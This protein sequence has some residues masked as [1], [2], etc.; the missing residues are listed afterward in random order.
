MR[1]LWEQPWY[2][3]SSLHAKPYAHISCTAI[4]FCCEHWTMCTQRLI[5]Q[6]YANCALLVNKICDMWTLDAYFKSIMMCTWTFHFF[7]SF[8]NLNAM[9]CGAARKPLMILL[10]TFGDALVEFLVWLGPASAL[11]KTVRLWIKEAM[12]SASQVWESSSCLVFACKSIE[13]PSRHHLVSKHP[14]QCQV[15]LQARQVCSYSEV[16]LWRGRNL[17]RW[18]FVRRN[19]AV[20]RVLYIWDPG[21]LKYLPL[22]ILVSLMMM[23]QRVMRKAEHH[24]M[25]R[26][27]P[28]CFM[29]NW[30]PNRLWPRYISYL[31]NCVKKF[32]ETTTL[33]KRLS[34]GIKVCQLFESGV[35]SSIVAARVLSE[36]DS[37]KKNHR[38]SCQTQR[39][40]SYNYFKSFIYF[41]LFQT[42]ECSPRTSNT[43][44]GH[45]SCPALQLGLSSFKLILRMMV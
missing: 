8:D 35:S 15:T 17:C 12:P 19:S 37:P 18:G 33:F 29:H 42:L 39:S 45:F 40:W 1:I 14:S 11:S 43:A 6:C 24:P 9:H 5:A 3:K 34:L 2:Q 13:G 7:V 21:G 30:G 22:S 36:S 32:L 10:K 25:L 38:A 44:S 27:Q 26:S 23:C 28:S 41:I 16:K 31:G 4:C 20:C